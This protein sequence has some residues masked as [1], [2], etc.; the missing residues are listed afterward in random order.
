LRMPDEYYWLNVDRCTLVQYGTV[1]GSVL[2]FGR[3]S[4]SGSIR[5][6]KCVA[7]LNV[8]CK[9]DWCVERCN[10]RSRELAPSPEVLRVST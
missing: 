8:E 10:L 7:G 3:P 1:Y 9:R 6:I 2:D 5:S 4:I